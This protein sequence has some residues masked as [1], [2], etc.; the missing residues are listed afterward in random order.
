MKKV[1]KINI[2]KYIKASRMAFYVT[3]YSLLSASLASCVD[4]IIL[5]DDK[6]VEEDWWQKKEQVENMVNG[7][8]NAMASS[9][10]QLRL[11]VWS[12]RSDE[13]N[14]NTSLSNS[15]LNQINSANIQTDNAYANWGDL[16]S[17]INCCNLVIDKSAEVMNID[18]SY[19][20]GDHNNNVAQMKALRSLCYLYLIRTFRDV[21]LVLT[22][23]KPSSQELNVEQVAPG[24]VL[25]QII[26]DLEE[27]KNQTLTTANVYTQWQKMGKITRNGV[28]AILA[29][30]YL[31]RA[32][33]LGNEADY[34]KCIECCDYIRA[35]RANVSGSGSHFGPQSNN[36]DDGWRLNSYIS[37]YNVFNGKDDES[38]LE[39]CYNDN[40]GLCNAYYKY[41]NS[42][43]AQPYFYTTPAFGK[44][45]K[46]A[47]S[48]VFCEDDAAYDVR[49]FESVYGFNEDN[50]EGIRIRKYV[51]MNGTNGQLS[52][53]HTSQRDYSPYQNNWIVYRTSDVMLMKAEAMTQKAALIIKAADAEYEKLATANS[54]NDS[55][56]IAQ[57]LEQVNIK[58]AAL[59]QTACR[60]V[61][62]VH[63]RA[64]TDEKE[65]SVDSTAYGFT[66]VDKDNISAYVSRQ[67]SGYTTLASNITT[68]ETLVLNER[69]RELC[70]EGKRWF[71]LLR[72]NYRHVE[73]V[74]YYRKLTDFGG[75]YVAN[76]AGFNSYLQRKNAGGSAIVSKMPSEPYLYMPIIKSE[77]DVNALLK[78]N[79]VYSDNSTM[80]KNY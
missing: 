18:P 27:V 32:S 3:L 29:D 15:A 10:I 75:K 36:D 37:Y 60:Q 11:I 41:K 79:P 19:L 78:Q 42:T 72:Y 30:A 39:L 46:D 69:A 70:F 51:A 80:D 17:V 34:D 24:V 40:V 63:T 8:Y 31:W 12:S 35:Q 68:L 14:V 66:T 23:F 55:L 2:S 13:L 50:D 44:A 56:A 76:Y 71:D 67:V 48:S 65:C 28:Y 62:I 54:L 16:Y 64:L 1:M 53:E 49:G 57:N 58:A 45:V 9:N 74:D 33:I 20:E 59:T 7:A 38:L 25:D 43:S 61:Q 4:T 5:P 52:A 47:S 73:G 21:P 6:T 22:P 77:T 26:A